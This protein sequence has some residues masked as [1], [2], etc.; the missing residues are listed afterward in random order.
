MEF[1][2]EPLIIFT[3]S[4]FVLQWDAGATTTGYKLSVP[5]LGLLRAEIWERREANMT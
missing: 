4:V 2:K 3:D 1:Y 5:K